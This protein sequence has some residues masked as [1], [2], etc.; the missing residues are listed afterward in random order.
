[1]VSDDIRRH[2]YENALVFLKDGHRAARAGWNGK[3]MWLVLAHGGTFKDAFGRV[4]GE[5]EPFVVMKTADNKFVPWLCSQTDALA[6]DW[7]MVA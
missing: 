4:Q 2:P 3:A 1:M 5:L 7:E 6:Q